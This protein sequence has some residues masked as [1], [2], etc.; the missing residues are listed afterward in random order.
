M[1]GARALILQLLAAWV[2]FPREV[3]GRPR[4]PSPLYIQPITFIATPPC[5]QWT[6]FRVKHIDSA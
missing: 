2:R 3:L 1:Q 4:N 5:L 6:L